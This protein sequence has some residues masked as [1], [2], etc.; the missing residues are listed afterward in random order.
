MSLVTC[1]SMP[2]P[3]KMACAADSQANSLPSSPAPVPSPTPAASK[4]SLLAQ[5][6]QNRKEQVLKS[7]CCPEPELLDQIRLLIDS[8]S[9]LCP[10]S[11]PVSKAEQL[12]FVC[13]F[14]LNCPIQ[15]KNFLAKRVLIMYLLNKVRSCGMCTLCL[16]G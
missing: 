8:V 12:K 11:D 10:L 7:G 3:D 1:V 14:T 5:F 16:L 2:F 6:L 13:F 9:S 15:V 4:P